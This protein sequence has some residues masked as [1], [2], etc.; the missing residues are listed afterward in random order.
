M[1]TQYEINTGLATRDNARVANGTRLAELN[2]DHCF[3]MTAYKKLT[4]EVNPT[5]KLAQRNPR[6]PDHPAVFLGPPM[7]VIFDL[8]VPCII[9]Y[10]WYDTHKSQWERECFYHTFS[11]QRCPYLKPEFDRHILGYAIISFGIGELYIL[12]VRIFRLL[13]YH[14]DSAPLLSHSTWELDATSWVYGVALICALIP[15]LIGSTK[16]IPKLYLYS[17]GVL[18]AFLGV[19]MFITLIPFNIPIRID[20]QVKRTPIRPFVYYACEDFIAVDGLQGRGF[21]RR[22]NIR[23][24]TSKSFR[25]MMFHLTLWWLLGVSFYLGVVSSVIW[26]LDFHYAFGLSLGVL[27]GWILIW[28]ALSYVYFQFSVKRREQNQTILC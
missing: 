5:E 15:F 26:V 7:I 25:S 17:P 19:L 11:G 23:Y 27:F 24:E 18:M 4:M 1:T 21:R 16:E 13:Q 8:V 6:F 22:Y 20:S 12:I 14:E 10:A 9:Y 28:V 2:F 3:T